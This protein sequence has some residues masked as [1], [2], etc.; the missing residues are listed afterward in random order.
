[1]TETIDREQEILW[2]TVKLLAKQHDADKAEAV[3]KATIE[4][5]LQLMNV[6]TPIVSNLHFSIPN[7][8]LLNELKYLDTDIRKGITGYTSEKMYEEILDYIQMI[9]EITEDPQRTNKEVVASILSKKSNQGARVKR[10]KNPQLVDVTMAKPVSAVIEGEK[11]FY[12]TSEA[13]HKLGLSDQ[14]IRRMCKNGKFHGAYRS[15]D[16][17]W[18]IPEKSFI[19]TRKQD[20]KANEI[21]KHLDKKNQE[22]GDI[23][24]FEF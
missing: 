21:L 4:K 15:E 3:L 18:R 9:S 12:T 24:E 6:Y 13:A 19:T 10:I 17:H 20:I 22:V 7:E 5:S 14:T 2:D 16:G 8:Q 11:E 1:M 23:D